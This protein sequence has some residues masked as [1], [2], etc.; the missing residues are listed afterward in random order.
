M[1]RRKPI[2]PEHVTAAMRWYQSAA[3]PREPAP[4]PPTAPTPPKHPD[5]R[6]PP[7]KP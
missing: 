3:P 5:E 1:K 7:C 4:A 2:T 6:K